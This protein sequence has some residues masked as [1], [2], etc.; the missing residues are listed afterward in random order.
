MTVL[1]GTGITS[2]VSIKTRCYVRPLL[3]VWMYCK[4]ESPGMLLA[5][6]WNSW[7]SVVGSL[8]VYIHKRSHWRHGSSPHRH[9]PVYRGRDPMWGT[10]GEALTT[11][12]PRIPISFHTWGNSIKN[13]AANETCAMACPR[14][15]QGKWL[16]RESSCI[17]W[18]VCFMEISVMAIQISRIYL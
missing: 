18:Y 10:G 9:C 1:W 11:E 15:M 12:N 17:M 16:S 5:T 2:N 3:T 4:A 8:C 13:I 6:Y 7:P 14:H